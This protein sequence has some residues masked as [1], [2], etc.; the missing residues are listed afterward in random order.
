[1]ILRSR[2]WKHCVNHAGAESDRARCLVRVWLRR[3]IAAAGGSGMKQDKPAFVLR[4]AAE[5][6]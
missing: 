2:I 3:D 6:S 5:Q 4:I 1:M